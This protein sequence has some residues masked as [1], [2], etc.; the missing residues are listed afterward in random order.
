MKKLLFIIIVALSVISIRGSVSVASGTTAFVFPGEKG[1]GPVGT[2]TINQFDSVFFDVA[3]AVINGTT[4]EFPVYLRSD[5]VINALDFAFKYD[6]THLEY[7]TIINLTTYIDPLTYY[8]PNDSM[9][10]L[11][12][13]SFTQ[14]YVNDTPLFII[15]FTLLTGQLCSNDLDSV[16]SLLNGDASTYTVSDCTSGL[17]D[18]PSVNSINVY[19][20]PANDFVTFDV[21][22]KSTVEIMDI[23]SKKVVSEMVVETP[24]TQTVNTSVIP[25][26]I[27]LLKITGNDYTAC[28]KLLISK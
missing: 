13:Y 25:N 7:D 14:A 22:V 11:T 2:T 5:D 18:L 15:R 4:V 8:N 12:S 24:G 28:S 10:R 23:S 19:P 3:Q 20:N 6:Q 1:G 17:F 21:P 16:S 9:V 26:G 27:Y